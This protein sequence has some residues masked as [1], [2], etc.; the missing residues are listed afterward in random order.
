MK[1]KTVSTDFRKS[2]QINVIKIRPMGAELFHA[3]GRMDGHTNM[4]VLIV[5]FRN[6]AKET[7]KSAFSPHSV[8]SLVQVA[9]TNLRNADAVS[10]LSRRD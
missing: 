6:F 10:A 4:V 9:S 3:E 1:L 5:T 8:A 7:K 2:A